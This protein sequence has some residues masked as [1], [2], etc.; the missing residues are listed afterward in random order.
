MCQ[1]HNLK[2]LTYGTLVSETRRMLLPQIAHLDRQCGGFLADQWI[3]LPEPD[4]YG[5][6]LSPSQRKVRQWQ[7]ACEVSVLLTIS[8]QYLDVIVNAWGTWELFQSLLRLLRKIG[9][10]HGVTVSNVATRWVL[11]HPF[12]GAVIIGMCAHYIFISQAYLIDK[13]HVWV[14]RIMPRTIPKFSASD[15][16]LGIRKIS[17]NC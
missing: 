13:A 4:P 3:G 5:D 7:I 6:K 11:D 9:D 17:T 8:S 15:L 2:L 12:V 1:K 16:R 10:R 14:F